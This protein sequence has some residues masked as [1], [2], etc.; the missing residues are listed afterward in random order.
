MIPWYIY[1][2]VSKSEILDNEPCELWCYDDAYAIRL[3][4]E[5]RNRYAMGYYNYEAFGRVLASAFSKGK[6]TPY[7]EQPMMENAVLTE[8]D[9][10]KQTDLL[11]AQLEMM[12]HNFENRHSKE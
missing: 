1:L 8:R 9:V 2:G 6:D 3:K 7:L 12:Q 10:K 11:F 5:D 4:E